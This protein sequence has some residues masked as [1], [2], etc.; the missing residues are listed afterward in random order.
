MKRLLALAA[1]AAGLVLTGHAT[2]QAFPTKPIR[3]V[4]PVPPGGTV[5]VL[6]R[7]Y[8]SELQKRLG[9]PVLVESRAGA[10]GTIAANAVKGSEADGYTLLFWT[11]PLMHPV[12]N[13]NGGGVVLG[14]DLAPVSLLLSTPSLWY[15]RAALP[16]PP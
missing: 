12:F 2:A 3:I 10:N 9:Q 13:P 16:V 1:L 8:A 7:V 4:I 5:D 15:V 6:A 14:K 11:A